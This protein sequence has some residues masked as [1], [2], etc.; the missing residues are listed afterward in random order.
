MSHTLPLR[1]RDTLTQTSYTLAQYNSPGHVPRFT[2]PLAEPAQAA[3]IF[4]RNPH[5]QS[6]ARTQ[7]VHSPQFRTGFIPGMFSNKAEGPK[8]ESM[9]N[10]QP[11]SL[12]LVRRIQNRQY[13]E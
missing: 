1:P 11:N 9:L 5:R 10:L 2:A 13:A 6:E 12:S 4:Q 7:Q 8:G 3:N